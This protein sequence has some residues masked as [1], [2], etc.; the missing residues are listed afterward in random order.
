M[1][2]P[3][4]LSSTDGVLELWQDAL[5][6]VQAAHPRPDFSIGL[7]TWQPFLDLY[8]EANNREGALAL[9]PRQLSLSVSVWRGALEAD[10][11][12]LGALQGGE[13]CCLSEG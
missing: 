9:S 6:W 3:V 8:L 11:I 10:K 1:N 13:I 12:D 7:S 5:T 4:F 2:S